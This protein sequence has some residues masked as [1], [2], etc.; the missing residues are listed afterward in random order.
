MEA[1][2]SIHMLCCMVLAAGTMMLTWPLMMRAAVVVIA[3]QNK[4]N[5]QEQ[6]FDVDVA[7]SGYNKTPPKSN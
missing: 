7:S 4:N 3:N 1:S 2:L 5:I 6:L